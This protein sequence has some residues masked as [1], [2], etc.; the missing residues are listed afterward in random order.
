MPFLKAE[1]RTR[2]RIAVLGSVHMDLIAHANRMPGAGESVNGDSFIMAPGGKGGNQAAQCAGLGADAFM[3]TKLGKDMFGEELLHA[4]QRRGVNIDRVLCDEARSTGA[5]TVFAAEG[6]YSSIICAGAAGALTLDEIE[7]ALDGIGSLDALLLQ[8]ELPLAISMHAALRARDKGALI[9]FNASPAVAPVE[10]L[11]RDFLHHISVLIVNGTEAS[12]LTGIADME[13]SAAVLGSCGPASV[14]ITLG[15]E[16]AVAFHE[17]KIWWQN[18]YKGDVTDSVGAGDA[19]LAALAVSLC[20]GTN[21]AEALRR[22]A[23]AGALAVS[24]AGASSTIFMEDIDILIGEQFS[25]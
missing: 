9:V 15:K 20:S 7:A 4:P 21:M 3:I 12:R 22:G 16:G 23:A 13:K 19:F 6:D 25:K 10:E 17:R 5:S 8:W 1:M 11:P 24:K 14:I 18:A 2:P